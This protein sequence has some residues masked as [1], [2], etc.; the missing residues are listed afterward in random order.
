MKTA[1][2]STKVIFIH[3]NTRLAFHRIVRTGTTAPQHQTS[4][5][6]L[7][8]S[9]NNVSHRTQWGHAYRR[10]VEVTGSVPGRETG[11][12]ESS[13]VTGCLC[14]HH[15]HIWGSGGTAPRVLKLGTRLGWGG[16]AALLQ[17]PLPPR[18]RNLK[19]T[20]SR[21]LSEMTDVHAYM[22]DRISH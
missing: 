12:S 8:L 13:K 16:G 5:T 21:L 20:D 15:K 22:M 4:L 10:L 7:S 2:C 18:D 6:N 17:S 14:L 1:V 3:Q 19:S 9:L 11:Y